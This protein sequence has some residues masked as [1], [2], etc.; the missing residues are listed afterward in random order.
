M[1]RRLRPTQ[2]ARGRCKEKAL[3]YV[4]GISLESKS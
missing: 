2:G 1:R 3:P 4:I